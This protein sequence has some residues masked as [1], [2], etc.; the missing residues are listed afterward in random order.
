[1]K[2]SALNLLVFFTLVCSYS[3]GQTGGSHAGYVHT[4]GYAGMDAKS[5]L[6]PYEF[7][8][9]AV[10]DDDILIDVLYSGICHSD[11][12]TVKGD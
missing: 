2:K 1:M 9:R 8:R 3:Y 12:H 11:I 6:V 7:E 10:G 4:K 5:D